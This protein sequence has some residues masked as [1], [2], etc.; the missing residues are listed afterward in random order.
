M[1][2]ILPSKAPSSGSP[3][4]MSQ[5]HISAVMPSAGM[6]APQSCTWV[7]TGMFSPSILIHCISSWRSG[8]S[9]QR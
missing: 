3:S 1:T 5:M 8:Q 7:A 9:S 6:S 2:T 4:A